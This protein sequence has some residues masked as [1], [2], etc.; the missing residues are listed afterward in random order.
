MYQHHLNGNVSTSSSID[1]L[2]DVN[3]TNLSNGQILKY[4]S[5]SQEWENANESGGGG[6]SA[7]SDLTDVTVTSP[8]DGQVLTYDNTSGKW[9]ND[10]PTASSSISTL[11]D[12]N[13]TSLSDGQIL[14]YDATNQEWVNADESGGGGGTSSGF[15]ELAKYTGAG[16]GY[17][18]GDTITLSDNINNYDVLMFA[19]NYEAKTTGFEN[20]LV[21]VNDFKTKYSTTFYAVYNPAAYADVKYATDTT[22]SVLRTNRAFVNAVYGMKLGFGGGGS[23]GGVDT[24]WTG[25]ICPYVSGVTDITLDHP[26]TDYDYILVNTYDTNYNMYGTSIFYD[27]KT[28]YNYED[29]IDSQGDVRNILLF[30]VLGDTSIRLKNYGQLGQCTH[31][32]GFYGVKLGGGGSSVTPN[33]Q[34]TPTDTLSTIEIN[35]TIYDIE[36]GSEGGQGLNPANYSTEE[37][38]IGVWTNNLPVYKKTWT[39]SSAITVVNNSWADTSI[40]VSD[41]QIHTIVNCEAVGPNGQAWTCIS[42]TTDEATQTYVRVLNTRNTDVN[43]KHLTLYYIKNGDSP[44]VPPGAKGEYN[45]YGGFIDTNNIIDSGSYQGS[46]TYTATENCFV[47]IAVVMSANNNATITIDGALVTSGWCASLNTINPILPLKKGQT[48]V[49][50]A[51]ASNTSNYTV[52]GISYGS[53]GSESGNSKIEYSTTEHKVGTWIDGSDVYEKTISISNVSLSSGSHE[54]VDTITELDTI[55]SCNGYVVEG[56]LKYTLNDITLRVIQDGTSV[57]LYSPAG[58]TWTISSGAIIIRYTKASS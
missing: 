5:T 22:I 26:H 24:L 47:N 50:T 40:S 37:E 3:L 15:V 25:D 55:I 30:Q 46:F 41:T 31:Y 21:T 19:S 2:T 18:A 10:T 1:T 23:T 13:L 16:A 51:S 6:S 42:A 57:K 54:T 32:T 11:T 20:A 36:G 4:N 52:Y 53:G 45:Y 7:L 9:V 43:V 35:G 29:T 44:I 56:N 28:N 39:F 14:K 8:S 38:I 58:T 27:L 17:A 49:A 33:P 12:V 34:G 48:L